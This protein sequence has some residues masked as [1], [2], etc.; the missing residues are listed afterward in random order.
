MKRLIIVVAVLAGALLV[1]LTIVN[2]LPLPGGGAPDLV[3]LC[4][5]AIGVVGG[6]QPGL[7]AGFCAGLAI[8]LAPP[9]DQLLGQY[10]LVFCLIGYGS[11]R[12]RF[13]VRQ[14]A[15]LALVAAAAAVVAGEAL[16]G[17]LAVVLDTPQVTLAAVAASLPSTML[18]DLLLIPLVMLAAVRAAVALGVR[19]EAID[20]S[21]ALEAGG[22]AQPL[23]LARLAQSW[24]AG[25]APAGDGIGAAGSWLTGDSAA[26]VP[27]MGAVGWLNGPATSRRARREQARLSAAVSGAAPRKGAVWVGSRPAG[28][29][30]SVPPTAPAQ[31]SGLSKLRPDGEVP[32]SV[33]RQGT[34]MAAPAK[35][36]GRVDAPGLPKIAFGSGGATDRRPPVREGVPKIAF[37]T[38]GRPGA[39]P[40]GRRVP[41][42]A[43]SGD[44][45]RA[46]RISPGRPAQP[47]FG[48]GSARSATGP[49][50]VG[51]RQ[52]P[53]QHQPKIVRWRQRRHLRWLGRISGKIGGQR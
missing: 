30:P 14:S 26:S 4:V 38:G 11:G 8:D 13:T 43:F 20:D 18:Y 34:P 28:L 42:I 49:W 39:R 19:L 24:T 10:A 52:R 9:A 35:A 32:G 15:G 6:P 31:P 48:S 44:L 12:L 27:A 22:S 50:L 45:P 41:K 23:G 51:P 53:V 21:P 46:P 16:A 36:D 40:S 25:H 29:R 17:C 3:L 1:Q 33:L 7:I 47:R 5:V 2:G 37:G